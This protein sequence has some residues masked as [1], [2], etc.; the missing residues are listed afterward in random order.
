MPAAWHLS[1]LPPHSDS[2][3]LLLRVLQ[4]GLPT[5]KTS[6][7]YLAP[8]NSG[9][10]PPDLRGGALGPRGNVPGLTTAK[11]QHLGQDPFF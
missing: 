7:T 9:S 11:E 6:Y 8:L 1:A 2:R 3:L 4:V 5:S 10:E